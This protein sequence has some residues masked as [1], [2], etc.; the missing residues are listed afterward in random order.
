M[1]ILKGGD[2]TMEKLKERLDT[3]VEN[4]Y[5]KFI[6]RVE[7]LEPK[8]IIERAY[9]ITTKEEIV[10][11]IQNKELGST[12]IKALLKTNDLL[13]ECY[14]QWLKTDGNFNELIDYAVDD[15]IDK[16]TQDFIAQMKQRNKKRECR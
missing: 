3:K 4:E 6:E 1:Q 5:K 13:G 8:K 15:R 12:D 11:L 16:I 7:K 9:E 14:V 10:I 2:Y